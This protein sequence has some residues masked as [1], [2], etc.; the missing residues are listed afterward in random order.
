VRAAGAQIRVTA[1][2]IDSRSGGHVWAERYEGDLG[3]IFAVQDQITLAIALAMQVKLAIGDKARFGE[4]QTRNLR[5]WEKMVAARDAFSRYNRV[6]MATARRLLEEALQ[7]DPDYTGAIVR[8]GM[9][10]WWDARFN[11]AI[12]T[13]HSLRLADEDSRK[14]LALNPDLGTAFMLKGGIAFLRDQHDQ[15]LKLAE[16]AVELAPSD[17]DSIAFLAM[18]YMYS[19]ENEKSLAALEFAIR[20][21]PQ[22]PSWYTYYQ[23]F[24]HM[25]MGNFAK[26]RELGELYLRQ[27]PDEPVGYT[28]M[29]TILAFQHCKKEAAEMIVRLRLR[30]PDFGMTEMRMSQHYRERANFEKVIKALKEAGLPE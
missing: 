2:L 1:H 9:T 27:E 4:G 15:A 16:R 11:K 5:A 20:L 13:E 18:L 21:C 22:Y 3:D 26:A 17:S 19:G 30:F 23:A 29:A 7:I 12:D 10:H 24:S 25:W 8:H 28:L 14:A 6:S